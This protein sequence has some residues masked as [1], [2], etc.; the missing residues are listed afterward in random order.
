MV[1][2]LTL[3]DTG[4]FDLVI[5]FAAGRK[6]EQAVGVGL[7]WCCRHAPITPRLA[8]VSV[9]PISTTAKGYMLLKSLCRTAWPSKALCW[10]TMSRAAD[11]QARDTEHIDTVA[12]EVLDEVRAK[13]KPL[14]GM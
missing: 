3:P 10:R 13:L 1:R 9:C 14:L 2:Y 12:T 4:D 7:G 6:R 11:W 8:S 5:V